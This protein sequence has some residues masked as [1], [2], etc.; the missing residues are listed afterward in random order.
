MARGNKLSDFEKGK[1]EAFHE[2]GKSNRQTAQFL[3][4]SHKVVDSYL[5]NPME[6]GTKKPSGRP[7]KLSEREERRIYRAVLNST[8]TSV[9]ITSDL[10]LNVA[11]RTARR[12]FVKNPMLVCRKMKRVPALTNDQKCDSILRDRT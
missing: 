6:Y 7:S 3:C 12:A 9:K 5:N 4:R 11:P 1:I 10:D 2:Q 8:K